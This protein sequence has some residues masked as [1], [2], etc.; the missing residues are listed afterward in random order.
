[1]LDNLSDHL[2]DQLIKEYKQHVD[3][4]LLDEQAWSQAFASVE[5][6]VYNALD[7]AVERANMMI[8]E[9]KHV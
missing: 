3:R 6:T 8:D 2:T 7:V 4:G 5:S 9:D 1:M